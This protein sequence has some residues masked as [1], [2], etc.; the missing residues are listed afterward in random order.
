[1]NPMRWM[2]AFMIAAATAGTPALAA[3]ESFWYG[4]LGAG[5]G[6]AK[7]T[8]SW[9]QQTDISL[10]AQGVTSATNISSWDTSWKIYGGY[11]FSEIIAAEAAYAKLGKF[12]GT[13]ALSTPAGGAGTGTWDAS[14]FSVSAVA[15]LPIVENR[16]SVLGKLGLAY[17]QLDVNETATGVGGSTVVV[18]PTN[19][20]TNLLVGL[21]L[22]YDITRK[23]GLR[24]EYEHYNN[25]GDGAV[26]GQT[27]IVVWTLGAQY[28][29]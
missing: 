15:T 6:N 19:K 11:Q 3:D 2:A 9:A 8:T 1:M 20:R 4:G 23:I 29:F 28:R 17:T 27:A 7:K 26:T 14:A 21:G 12:G 22:R 25:V 16:F 13:S 10:L 18:N 5:R 24:A